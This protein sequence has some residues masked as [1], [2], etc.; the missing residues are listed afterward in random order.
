MGLLAV[1]RWLLPES[2]E[3]VLLKLR[4]RSLDRERAEA[5]ETI[6]RLSEEIARLREEKASLANETAP[7]TEAGSEVAEATDEREVELSRNPVC[8]YCGQPRAAGNRFEC[9]TEWA[10]DG[11]VYEHERTH[12]CRTVERLNEKITGLTAVSSKLS[13]V[14]EAFLARAVET[15]RMPGAVVE[16]CR[17]CSCMDHHAEDCPVPQAVAALKWR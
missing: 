9:G 6:Q 5:R 1:L 13:R 17:V 15:K 12:E 14:L 11:R 8:P 7:L 3:D 16:I 10:L 4:G 2:D